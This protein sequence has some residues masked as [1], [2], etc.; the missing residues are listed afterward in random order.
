MIL[1][2]GTI[3]AEN[4]FSPKFSATGDMEVNLVQ[5][6]GGDS[7]V[8]LRKYNPNDKTTVIRLL[9]LTESQVIEVAANGWFDIG[10]ATGGYVGDVLITVEAD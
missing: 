8:T 4:T 3:T 2:T 7:T 5:G 9:E 1:Y 10:V 6:S